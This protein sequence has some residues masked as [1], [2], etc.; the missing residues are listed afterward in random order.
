MQMSSGS[1]AVPIKL[2]RL[3]ISS[4][5]S[6]V[7]ERNDPKNHHMDSGNVM[8][9]TKP[10]E[11]DTARGHRMAGAVGLTRRSAMGPKMATIVETSR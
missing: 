3:M 6:P 4:M 8:S 2:L 5:M 9:I 11:V 10:S 1:D 7:A